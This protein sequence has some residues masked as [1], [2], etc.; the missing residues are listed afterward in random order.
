MAESDTRLDGAAMQGGWMTTHGPDTYYPITPP[1]YVPEFTGG[2]N[3][4]W[5]KPKDVERWANKYA[6]GVFNCVIGYQRFSCYPSYCGGP[7]PFTCRAIGSD[8]DHALVK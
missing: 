5:W 4:R 6:S 3:G 2:V 8:G 7:T 1:F